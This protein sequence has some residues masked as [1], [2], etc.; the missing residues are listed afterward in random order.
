[1]KYSVIIPTLNE[2][3]LLPKILKQL[4]EKKL[5]EKIDYEII[6]SDGGSRDLT[7]KIAEEFADKVVVSKENHQTI[8]KGRNDG[9]KIASGDILIFVNGDII[10]ENA[11]K[12]FQFIKDRFE[13]SNYAAMTCKVKVFPDEEIISDRLFHGFYNTYFKSLN[14]FGMGMGRGE[15]QVIRKNVFEKIGGNREHL[16]AGEDFDLYMRIKKEG[17][18][19]FADE[20][21]VF[22]SPRRYRKFGYFNVT[23][24]WLKN[25]VSVVIKKKSISLEWE[26]VR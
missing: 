9:A 26:Q 4:T 10:F 23:F 11:E 19:L 25:S 7:V 12:F 13:N 6:V 22:E 1:M 24:S 21:C 8:A 15:C 20:I 3:K 5:N 2:E 17:K 14:I 16:I 18:I